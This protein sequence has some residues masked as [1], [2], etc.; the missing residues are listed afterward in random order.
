MTIALSLEIE[1]RTYLQFIGQHDL[2]K[3]SELL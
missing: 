1:S 2:M 3:Q